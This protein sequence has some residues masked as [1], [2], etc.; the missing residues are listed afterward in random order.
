MSGYGNVINHILQYTKVILPSFYCYGNV[1][2][3]K[4]LMAKFV[5]SPK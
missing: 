2:Y 3:L 5:F 1:E 4:A